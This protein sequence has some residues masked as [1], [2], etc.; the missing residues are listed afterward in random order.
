MIYLHSKILNALRK[1]L[2]VV[3]NQGQAFRDISL[4]HSNQVSS[5]KTLCNHLPINKVPDNKDLGNYLDEHLDLCSVRIATWQKNEKKKRF[6]QGNT[7][8]S[9]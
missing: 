7:E 3:D 9:L 2:V 1:V 5:Y 6:I 8:L 4:V